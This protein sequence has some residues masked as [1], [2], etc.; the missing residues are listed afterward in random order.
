MLTPLHPLS[1]AVARAAPLCF[2]T[3]SKPAVGRPPARTTSLKRE[4][5]VAGYVCRL[6]QRPEGIAAPFR[7]AEQFWDPPPSWYHLSGGA[8][9]AGF[10]ASA[11]RSHAQDPGRRKAE[12]L[13]QLSRRHSKPRHLLAVA[14]SVLPS[15]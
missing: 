8:M 11:S 13:V 1:A 2:G 5:G 9:T 6:R 4:E 14:R 3:T 12:D 10:V 15:A 7:T